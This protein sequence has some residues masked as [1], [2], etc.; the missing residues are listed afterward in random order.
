M[1]RGA[2]N[3]SCYQFHLQGIEWLLEGLSDGDRRTAQYSSASNS[4]WR[5]STNDKAYQPG[6]IMEAE[7][8]M[9]NPRKIKLGPYAV[10]PSVERVPDAK[11][12]MD[13]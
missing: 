9:A 5:P 3:C 12:K 10:L 13:Q 1:G 4:W 11:A 2:I 8:P 6:A 7:D